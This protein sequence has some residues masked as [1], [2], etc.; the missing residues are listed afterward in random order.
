MENGI[1]PIWVFDNKSP[2][3][4]DQTVK[5]T[6]QMKEEVKEV[7]K[8][9]GYPIIQAKSSAPAQCAHLNR[10]GIVFGIGSEDLD[11]LTYGGNILLRHFKNE[12]KP[13]IQI[14]RE[15]VLQE[16]KLT[17]NQFIDLCILCGTEY[18]PP[19]KNIAA[20]RALNYIREY[21]TL[22]DTIKALRSSTTKLKMNLKYQIPDQYY[23]EEAFKEFSN[24]E[25]ND[26]DPLS[27][28]K[29]LL[30]DQMERYKY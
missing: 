30:V 29:V 2:K 26:I 16:L 19:I 21:G 12:K 24:P 3:S 13:A 22:K 11:C 9:F 5:V 23:H 1:R 28:I 17:Q 8:I 4:E 18:T 6:P 27:V 7:F 15:I 10:Q 20:T 14:E 25:V